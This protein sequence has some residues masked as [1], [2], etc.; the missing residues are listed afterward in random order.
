MLAGLI[1]YESN[2]KRDHKCEH[3]VIIRQ[4]NLNEAKERRPQ[5]YVVISGCR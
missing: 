4:A 5:F 2:E 3:M 1:M